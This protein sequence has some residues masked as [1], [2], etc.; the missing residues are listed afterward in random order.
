MNDM[1]VSASLN[2]NSPVTSNVNRMVAY[3]MIFQI[4]NEKNDYSERRMI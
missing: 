2:Q 3:T 4:D 1:L